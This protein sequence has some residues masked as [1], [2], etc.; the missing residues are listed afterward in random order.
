MQAFLF[1]DSSTFALASL[2][3]FS[4]S[5]YTMPKRPKRAKKGMPHPIRFDDEEK[6][7]ITDL[8]DRTS[9]ALSVNEVM[10]RA[11]R[12]A[13]PKFISGEAPLT[14]LKAKATEPAAAS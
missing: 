11:I 2:L 9:P 3:R 4:T 13:V 14:T 6:K 1:S 12:Y 5:L 10:R 7:L 8:Q